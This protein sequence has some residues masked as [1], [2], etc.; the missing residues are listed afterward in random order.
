MDKW[1]LLYIG[2]AYVEV[3]TFK[4]KDYVTV[5]DFST[6]T[7][8]LSKKILELEEENRKLKLENV[9]LKEEIKTDLNFE[10]KLDNENKKLRE[11]NK[12]LREENEKLK[13][14]LENLHT[15]Y[16]AVRKDK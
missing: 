4:W 9:R 14:E 10:E 16:R 3:H 7:N 6:T 8:A 2:S 1:D 11:E 13:E 5:R 15:A 12:K